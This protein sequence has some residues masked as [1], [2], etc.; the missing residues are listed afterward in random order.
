MA[1]KKQ[2]NKIMWNC[3][4]LEVKVTQEVT[5]KTQVCSIDFEQ[6]GLIEFNRP[7]SIDTLEQIVAHYKDI[8]KAVYA[9]MAPI[10]DYSD[11]D[12]PF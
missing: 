9:S 4:D 6:S 7:V 8:S 5:E 1:K 10:E 2:I 3:S 11:D 12:L